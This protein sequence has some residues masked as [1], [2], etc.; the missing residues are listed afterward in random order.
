MTN[1]KHIEETDLINLISGRH[2]DLR[3][4]VEYMT[5][6]Q[7]P[8]VHL[9]SSE[10]YLIM[11]IKYDQPTFA[12]LTHKINLTRQ[13]IHKAVKQLEQK[14]VVQIESVPNNKKEKRVTLTE[15]GIM[16]YEKYMKN[17]QHII[18]HIGQVIGASEVAHLEQLLQADW[19][20]ENDK[21]DE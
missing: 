14:Q 3:Q 20:L 21:P 19:Q 15:F 7:L 5:A 16:C 11:I 13:A 8:Q 17:K 12:E 9:G 4:K 10:W 18:E 1:H 2:H 6:Q